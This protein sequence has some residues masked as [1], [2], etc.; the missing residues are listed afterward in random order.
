MRNTNHKTFRL[1]GI[2]Q[3][4]VFIY[5]QLGQWRTLAAALAVNARRDNRSACDVIVCDEDLG[6]GFK[7]SYF[8]AVDGGAL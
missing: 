2:F 8:S 5:T 3:G 1:G 7:T 6:Y 4:R